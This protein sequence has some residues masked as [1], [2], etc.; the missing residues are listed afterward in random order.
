[1]AVAAEAE[2]APATVY[3]L[4]GTKRE[5]LKAVIDVS[6]G[7]DD[8]PIPFNERPAVV[9]LLN[10]PDPV[11]YLAGFARLAWEVG[12]RLDPIYD[13]VEAAAAVDPDSAELVSLM[14]EQRFIGQGRIARGLADR[15]ALRKGLT[16]SQA[17]DAIYALHSPELRR[18]L[19]TERRWTQAAYERW[20][21]EMLVAALLEPSRAVT[22]V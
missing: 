20:L 10:E 13:I 7:G 6:S 9:A 14:R 17:H 19:L 5:L 16:V 15:K 21:T 3:R 8:D 12:Q 22:S 18:V 2:V 11:S 4:F 1:E